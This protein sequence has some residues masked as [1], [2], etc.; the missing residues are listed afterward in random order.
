MS[1]SENVAFQNFKFVVNSYTSFQKQKMSKL[2][3]ETAWALSHTLH[4]TE[5]LCTPS[6][7]K[8]NVFLLSKKC[9]YIK[10]WNVYQ[11]LY[12]QYWTVEQCGK[13]VV[14]VSTHTLLPP[15]GCVFSGMEAVVTTSSPL[16]L[17]ATVNRSCFSKALSSSLQTL[18][19][20]R[21]SG[22]YAQSR[23]PAY[24]CPGWGCFSCRKSR[25]SRI[26]KKY[27]LKTL[28]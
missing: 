3:V 21:L 12:E 25:D 26:L 16:L 8:G 1:P 14:V 10:L 20:S 27:T 24:G 7:C 2:S 18:L 5:F 6:H 19:P 22:R 9:L 17:V 4:C 15:S 11:I 13:T 23:R 28:K